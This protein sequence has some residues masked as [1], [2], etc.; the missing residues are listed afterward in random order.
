MGSRFQVLGRDWLHDKHFAAW[1]KPASYD[2]IVFMEY[3][4]IWEGNYTP[5]FGKGGQGGFCIT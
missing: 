4:K 5:P 1:R 3:P 2:K